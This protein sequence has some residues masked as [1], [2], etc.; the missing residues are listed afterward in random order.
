LSISKFGLLQAT[1]QRIR[2]EVNINTSEDCPACAGTGKI[3]SALLL[4]DEMEKKLAYLATHGH[5]SLV[6]V[7]HPIIHSHLTKG[8]FTSIIK[9]WKKKYKI[10]LK[11]QASN[12]SHLVKY[13]FLDDQQEEIVI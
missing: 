1:R 8:I 5:K 2:P 4:E 6:L 3:T 11:S 7:V 12:A 13:Q 9:R 10:K